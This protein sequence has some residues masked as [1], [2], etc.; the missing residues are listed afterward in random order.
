LGKVLCC[1][2]EDLCSALVPITYGS[3]FRLG[4]KPVEIYRKISVH[5]NQTHHDYV[6]LC[7]VG[8]SS[9]L[10]PFTEHGLIYIEK[11]CYGHKIKC[12]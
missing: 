1:N 2:G 7:A 8:R 4:Q 12:N 6:M 10:P 11:W 5:M 9:N 3:H